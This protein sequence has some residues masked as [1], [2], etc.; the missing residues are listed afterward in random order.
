MTDTSRIRIH[1][2]TDVLCIWAYLAQIRLDELYKNFASEIEVT[3]HFMPVF[4]HTQSRIGE[5]WKDKGGFEGFSKKM[6]QVIKQFPHVELHKDICCNLLN[7]PLFCCKLAC[8]A[9]P[10]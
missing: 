5:G 9:S 3:H 7:R 4:G 10:R 6:H 1:Y 2:F 8:P